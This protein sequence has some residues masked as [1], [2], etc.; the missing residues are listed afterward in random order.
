MFGTYIHKLAPDMLLKFICV[1]TFGIVNY[2]ECLQL[3]YWNN[4]A[5]SGQVLVKNISPVVMDYQCT[6]SQYSRQQLL[7]LRFMPRRLSLPNK[8]TLAVLKDCD[9]LK[10]RGK[11]AGRPKVKCWSSNAGVR[12]SNLTKIELDH[13]Y[14]L[15]AKRKNQLKLAT[16]NSRSVRGKSAELLQHIMEE[17]IDLC[18]I[19][20]TWLR[21]DGDDVFRGE[22][23]QDGYR[24]DDVPR[25]DRNGG[26]VALL[27]R[28]NPRVSKC[29]SNT[30]Q[31]F[32]CSKTFIFYVFRIYLLLNSLNFLNI[33][34]GRY[35]K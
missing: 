35:H 21:A 20:E 28:D 33:H 8:E 9:I 11:R 23:S 4:I 10:Y 17:K 16:V 32:E 31:S 22:L 3:Q 6:V 24:F 12:L 7:D 30:F 18:L 25:R 26:G 15:N 27:Y 13:T 29:A 5:I 1:Y 14:L 2:F 19:T 34:Q